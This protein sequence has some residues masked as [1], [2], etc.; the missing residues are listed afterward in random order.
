MVRI[1]RDVDK[2]ESFKQSVDLDCEEAFSRILLNGT[3]EDAESAG[4]DKDGAPGFEKLS[5]LA[6]DVNEN[7][8]AGIMGTLDWG[9]FRN[10]GER[11]QHISNYT[12]PNL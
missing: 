11:V 9:A 2:L 4:I 3:D 8:C 7:R 6:D 12:I 5:T 10:G 1:K